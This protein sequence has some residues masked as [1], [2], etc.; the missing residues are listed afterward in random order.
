[1]VGAS[2]SLLLVDYISSNNKN[3]SGSSTSIRVTW[4]ANQGTAIV[5]IGLFAGSFITKIVSVH[6]LKKALFSY[7]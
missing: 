7:D 4:G 6:F 5:I 1:M 2:A 3:S